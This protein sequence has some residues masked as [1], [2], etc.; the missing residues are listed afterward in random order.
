MRMKVKTESCWE[1]ESWRKKAF[2]LDF[3]S[4]AHGHALA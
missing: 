1:K 4:T 3:Y 2:L